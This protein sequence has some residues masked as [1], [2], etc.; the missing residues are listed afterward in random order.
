MVLDE[1]L[2]LD[3]SNFARLLRPGVNNDHVLVQ[4]VANDL[5]LRRVD[6]AK[7]TKNLLN[8][9]ELAGGMMLK[10]KQD[11][12]TMSLDKFEAGV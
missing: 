7:Y 6:Y 8:K 2:G 5:W 10:L 4:Q 12:N 11:V 3:L 9:R 1:I